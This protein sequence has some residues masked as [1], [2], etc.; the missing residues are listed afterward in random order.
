MERLF[1][2]YI[3]MEINVIIPFKYSYHDE[4]MSSKIKEY[5]MEA[6]EDH[7]EEK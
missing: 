7:N 4:D 5:E 1:F 2:Q 3:E 6:K